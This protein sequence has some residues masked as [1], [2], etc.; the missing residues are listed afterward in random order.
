MKARTALV[1]L[2]AIALFAWFLRNAN[3]QEVW[4][5]VRSA[6]VSYL[7]LA[8][9]FAA[10]PYWMR[11]LRWQCLLAPIGT[12][13]FRVAFRATVIGF[14]ALGLLP[15][16]VGDVLRPYLLARQERLSL[17]ATLATVV[18]ERVLDLVAVL[19][20]L[21][22]YVWGFL[23]A[24]GFSSRL[25]QPIKAAA[26]MAAAAAAALVVLMWILA[27]H[28]ERIGGLVRAAGRV[29][30]HR[31]ADRVGGIASTFSTGFAATR[32]PR[33]FGMA[34]LWS[35]PIWLAFCA[36]TWAVTQAFGIDVPFVGTFLLQA[37]LV[38]GVAVPTPGGVGG[39][40]EMY[41]VGVTSFF[42]AGNEAAVAAAIVLHA[43]SFLPVMIVGSL[44]MMQD[45]LSVGRLR[46][47]AGVAREGEA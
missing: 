20:L 10:M 47:M 8:L 29:L 14:A 27:T 28:P 35:F 25:M 11:A 44:F 2:L 13:S 6:N 46:Q 9:F 26:A 15:G 12:T 1:T 39:F 7:F 16:R 19:V 43:L 41:R 24:D 23:D 17:S 36:E 5:H 31:L 42:G 4:S 34:V 45:G 21:A 3:L 40:H 18:M 22:V 33:G 37:M 30:P 38:I 32:D